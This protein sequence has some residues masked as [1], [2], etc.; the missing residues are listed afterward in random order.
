METEF[1]WE[2]AH[3]LDIKRV[4]VSSL[5]CRVFATYKHCY[6]SNDIAIAQEQYIDTH[7]LVYSLFVYKYEQT[8]EEGNGREK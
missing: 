2:F 3:T 1:F 6:N 5:F 4:C 8:M 7:M